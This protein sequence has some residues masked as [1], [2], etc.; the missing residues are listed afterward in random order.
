MVT[1]I[2]DPKYSNRKGYDEDFIDIAVPMP[3]VTDKKI[4]SK[5]DDG[6]FIIPYQHFSV[7]MN[8]KRRLALFT[9]SNVDASAKA[10]KPDPDAL[11]TRKTLT[12]LGKNDQE[13]W[14]TD[15][16]IPE[17]QQLPDV[18]YTK[19]RQSFDK[20]HIVRRDD[21]C[22]GRTYAQLRRA[23]GDTFH[24]TNCSPQVQEFNRS[25]DSLRT[26]SSSRPRQNAWRFSP[27]RYSMM[28]TT[29]SKA[30]TNAG[31]SACRF[32]GATG[33]SCLRTHQAPFRRLP[34][35]LSRT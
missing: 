31:P 29:C 27:G 25:G 6:E 4:V 14:F 34:S 3:K 20:G 15:P 21:V 18:F 17:E 12:G 7:V 2:I 9:A 19:D 22:W 11:Y 26:S 13:L 28:T 32:R 35:F 1:P 24:T 8:K 33:K 23:N 5:M 30:L 16:R 10:R